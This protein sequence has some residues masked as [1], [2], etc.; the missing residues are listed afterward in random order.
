MR[1]FKKGRGFI[2]SYL[3]RRLIEAQKVDDEVTDKYIIP[4][5]KELIDSEEHNE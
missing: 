5:L 2:V 3:E 4:Y 1:R